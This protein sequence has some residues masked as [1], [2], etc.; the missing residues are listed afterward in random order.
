MTSEKC[1]GDVCFVTDY[2]AN[3]SF[4]ALKQ[5]V[6]YRYEPNYAVLVRTTDQTKKWNGNYVYVTEGSYNFLSK[7]KL[8]PGD[9]IMANVGEP[10]K[11]FILPD[12]GMPMTLGPNAIVIRSVDPNYLN[13]FL[14]FYFISPVGKQK[15]ENIVTGTAVKKFNKTSF[16]KIDVPRATKKEQQLIVS[17]IE[18]LFSEVDEGVKSLKTLRQQLKV[19]R[20]AVLKWAFEGRLTNDNV[21]DGELPEG[22]EIV[23]LEK[24]ANCLDHKR[25]PVNRQ[26]REKRVGTVP[27]YG[28]NGRTG[29]ID[30]YL[31]DEPLILVVEDETFVGRELPFSYKITGKSW[32]NNHAHILK[33]KSDT[34][35]DF[36]NYQLFYYP[37]LPIVTGTTGRKKLTKN[38]LMNIPV[39]TCSAQQ[40][41]QI[42]QEIE[43]RL[44]VCDKIEETIASAMKEA[45]A[46]RHSILKKAFEG[47][48]S[49]K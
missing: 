16:K 30:N 22:W 32:V 34:D 24:I 12:L 39:K 35:I 45:E 18:E 11:A 27:Y 43:T 36:L 25:K 3:G 37:F 5:N 40:Q 47:S 6:E 15:L 49:K 29:W 1:I 28:A 46:L 48:W 38:V 17:K 10:G 8:Y 42:V 21:K 26:E 19:Y 9:V 20:Q 13:K 2:V 14:Y 33:P 44:S 4:A 31:F 23:T 41:R 7:S